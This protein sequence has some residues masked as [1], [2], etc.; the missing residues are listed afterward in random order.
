[1]LLEV[2]FIL[3]TNF[4]VGNVQDEVKSLGQQLIQGQAKQG[5]S[6][7]SIGSVH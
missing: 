7:T 6:K 5:P 3:Q 1:M 4:P 2:E